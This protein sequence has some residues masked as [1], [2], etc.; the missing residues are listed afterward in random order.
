VTNLN[1]GEVAA[2]KGKEGSWGGGLTDVA[3]TYICCQSCGCV[4]SGSGGNPQ[5]V[6]WFD[7]ATNT[8]PMKIPTVQYSSGS[9][10]FGN[11]SLDTGPYGL[12]WGLDRVLYAGNIDVNGDYVPL[13]LDTSTKQVIATFP[14]RV[15]ASA[16]FD[17]IHML[18]VLEGGDVMLVPVL[19]QT[20][21]PEPLLSLGQHATSIVRDPWSGTIYAELSD[22][23]IVSFSADG[24]GLTTF[25]TAP[26]LGRVTIAPDGYLYHLT[27]GWP[28]AAEV[29][30]WQL[31]TTL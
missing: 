2:I 30:R 28:T 21:T 22:R 12:S 14:S 11:T 9:G 3:L 27:A 1:M 10:P 8:L 18:V 24:T 6:A 16:P 19:G 29:V 20:G 17:R 7:P 25:Q 13:D 23:T 26:A 5:G 31:P 4:L 15:H